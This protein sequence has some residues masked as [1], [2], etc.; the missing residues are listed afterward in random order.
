MI[1]L[2]RLGQAQGPDTTKS[3]TSKIQSDFEKNIFGQKRPQHAMFTRGYSAFFYVK[4]T[5]GL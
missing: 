1:Y 5:L 3:S 2:K 4:E